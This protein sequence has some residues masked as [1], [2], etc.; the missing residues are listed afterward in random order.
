MCFALISNRQNEVVQIKIY[1]IVAGGNGLEKS[2]LT[3]V[4][5][6]ETTKLGKIIDANKITVKCGENSIEGVKLKIDPIDECLDKGISFTQ[7][8]T[9]S[10]HKTLPTVK[11]AIKK[12][13]YVRLYY[14][15]LNIVEESILRIENRVRK[16]GHNISGDDVK[17]RF[18]KRFQDLK[19]IIEY[20]DKATFYDNENGF[21]AVAEYRNGELLLIGDYTPDWLNE[22]NQIL[23]FK[24]APTYDLGE[25]FLRGR[26]V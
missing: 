15:A 22:L 1:T 3:G 21:V 16:G 9:L 18:A 20:C 13:Y 8:T 12:G 25:R 14:V 2:S 6:T 11:R 10:D 24:T 19:N 4:L 5:Q 23:Q 26:A 17:H 7:E